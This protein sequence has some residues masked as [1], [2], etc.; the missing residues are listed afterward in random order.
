MSISEKKVTRTL[1]TTLKQKLDRPE[2]VERF[3]RVFKEKTALVTPSTRK[4][5][6]RPTG[7]SATWS[8][9]SRT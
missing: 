2:L 3:V 6:T 9:G 7:A 1:V 8:A 4:L 5:P